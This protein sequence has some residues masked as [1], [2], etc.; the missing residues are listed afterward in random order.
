V[1]RRTVDLRPGGVAP[2]L[3]IVSY[4]R[5]GPGHRPRLTSATIAHASRT[6]RGIPEVMIKVSGGARTVRGVATHLEYLEKRADLETDDGEVLTEKG[7]ARKL[8]EDWD[9]ALDEGR[10]HRQRGIGAGRR[11]PKLV[12]NIVFSMP[13]GTPPEKLKKAV[14]RFAT[15]KF[16]AQHRY[17]MALHT[18]Q[19]HPHVHMV[20]KA[21]S[22]DGP[23]LNI[24]KAT[25]REWRRD[26]A[27]YLR[28]LGVEANATERAV[29]G[30][31]YPN[32]SAALYRTA[33]RGASTVMRER[34]EGVA[35][36]IAERA[37]PMESGKA[38]L[39]ATRRQV[40]EG[41]LAFAE[42]AEREGLRDL[43][44][45]ARRFLERMPAPRTERERIAEQLL[46][47]VRAQER[48][49]RTL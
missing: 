16:G 47:R 3:D 37:L 33:A 2:L 38:K 19:A 8:L 22:E 44:G 10:H 31:Q 1:R 35:R 18:D 17:V 7:L 36:A 9:L 45:E 15:E 27:R 24:Y 48:A 41:W 34:V 21:R 32:R 29:R 42:M 30:S 46:A 43:A 14:Q 5:R 11:T 23:R 12:H 39:V 4:G 26:F 28:E 40:T 13:K 25:L 49:L 20:V 6:V